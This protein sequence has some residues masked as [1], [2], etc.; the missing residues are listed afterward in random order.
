[1]DG[2]V[3]HVVMHGVIF[4]RMSSLAVSLLF[5]VA[6]TAAS[7]QSVDLTGRY[8]CTARCRGEYQPYITQNG[9]QLNVVTE[10]GLPSR[11]WPDWNFPATRI[12]VEMMGQ[13]AVYTPDGMTIQFD[14]GT[15]WQR[16]LPPPPPPVR[17]RR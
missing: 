6:A 8:N 4:M 13:S 11:A 3:V 16:D 12:W 10:A 9:P 7:A 15:V 1:M 14:G 17:R 2:R 5:T